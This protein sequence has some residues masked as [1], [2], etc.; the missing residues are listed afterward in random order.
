MQCQYSKKN[1]SSK[2]LRSLVL[3]MDFRN[4]SFEKIDKILYSQLFMKSCKC[5]ERENMHQSL[6]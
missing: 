1:Y 3:I 5:E 4:D 2:I 6:G